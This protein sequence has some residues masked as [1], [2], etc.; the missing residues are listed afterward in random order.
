MSAWRVMIY[1]DN[2]CNGILAAAELAKACMSLP[3]AKGF[4]SGEFSLSDLLAP[5]NTR[6]FIYAYAHRLW[7][8]RNP[9]DRQGA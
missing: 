9:S 5:S 3:A 4:E 2:V 8:L 1:I 6:L 7:F